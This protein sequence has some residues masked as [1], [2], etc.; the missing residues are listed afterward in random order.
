MIRDETTTREVNLSASLSMVCDL[1]CDNIRVQVIVIVD[2][3]AW[4][5][6]LSDI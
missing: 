6:R 1:V 2:A 5:K 4:L 3:L